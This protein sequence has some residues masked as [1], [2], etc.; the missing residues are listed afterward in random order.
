MI[1]EFPSCVVHR[2]SVPCRFRWIF[3]RCQGLGS[4]VWD[5]LHNRVIVL[6]MSPVFAKLVNSLIVSVELTS[7]I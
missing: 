5:V 1:P 7:W 2:P 3:V 4:R 6:D